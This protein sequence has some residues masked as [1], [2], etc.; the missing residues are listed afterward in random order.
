MKVRKSI[1]L[2]PLLTVVLA[3]CPGPTPPVPP[4]TPVEPGIVV[5]PIVGKPPVISSFK[6]TPDTLPAG[7]GSTA[8]S[9]TVADATKITLEGSGDVTGQ[10]SKTVSVTGTKTLT[11]TAENASGS[12]TATVDVTVGIAGTQGG[13]WD[14]SNWNEANWQ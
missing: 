3:A 5:V 10:T 13:V 6:A 8:L 9:W 12:V 11:L 2:L 7:G 4:V 1:W 14:S